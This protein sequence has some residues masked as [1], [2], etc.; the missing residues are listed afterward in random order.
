[1]DLQDC[2]NMLQLNAAVRESCENPE[3]EERKI[4]Y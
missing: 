4:L 3:I 2:I 1:M